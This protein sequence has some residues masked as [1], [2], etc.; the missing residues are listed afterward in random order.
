VPLDEAAGWDSADLARELAAPV[1]LVVGLRLGCINHALL[2]VEAIARRGLALA[3]WIGNRIDPQML[4]AAQNIDSL[5]ER[6]AAPLLG[7]L[8]WCERPDPAAH[9]G[10]VRLPD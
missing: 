9:A 4:R 2:T 5:R 10:H 7:V 3:G 1:I 8:P 6:I